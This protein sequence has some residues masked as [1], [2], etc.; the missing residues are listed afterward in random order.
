M[1][2]ALT[3]P[4]KSAKPARVKGTAGTGQGRMG[5]RK[6]FDNTLF[7]RCS[8]ETKQ[9]IAALLK[10]GEKEADFVRH[11]V[12]QAIK[13]RLRELKRQGLPAPSIDEPSC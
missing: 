8:G 13:A 7:T 6:E 4:R 12:E 3:A 11:A 1:E 2:T 9:L 5:R 10:P